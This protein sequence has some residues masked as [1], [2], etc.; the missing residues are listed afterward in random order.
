MLLLRQ[1]PEVIWSVLSR[2][3]LIW[4]A[5]L[6]YRL[7]SYKLYEEEYKKVGIRIYLIILAFFVYLFLGGFV[8][9]GLAVGVLATLWGLK[10]N[11]DEWEQNNPAEEPENGPL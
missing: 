6:G 2:A 3:L 4:A 10:R 7:A 11:Y 9:L 5:Y 1:H 8:G